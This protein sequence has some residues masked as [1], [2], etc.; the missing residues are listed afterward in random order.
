MRKQIFQTFYFIS[1]SL[2]IGVL[3]PGY[4]SDWKN[5]LQAYT[6]SFII[7]ALVATVAPEKLV[8]LYFVVLILIFIFSLQISPIIYKYRITIFLG[9]LVGAAIS[10]IWLRK[11]NNKSND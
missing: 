3:I 4:N 1:I 11:V 10:A 2:T 7:G 6:I 8:T 9:N 5:F